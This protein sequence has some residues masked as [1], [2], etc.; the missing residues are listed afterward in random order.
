MKGGRFFVARAVAYDLKFCKRKVRPIC[1]PV[2]R[3]A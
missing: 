2:E 3:Y 1:E